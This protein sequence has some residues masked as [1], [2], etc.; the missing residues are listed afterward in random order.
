MPGFFRR[1]CRQE[2]QK[3]GSELMRGNK[4]ENS[5]GACAGQEVRCG[6]DGYNTS[7]ANYSKW[8]CQDRAYQFD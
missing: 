5:S 3:V 2:P 1:H 6:A 7:R 8:L 4:G